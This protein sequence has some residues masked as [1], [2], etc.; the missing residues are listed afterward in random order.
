MSRHRGR[1]R[2]VAGVANLV[3]GLEF[4]STAAI[5]AAATLVV[6]DMEAGYDY[7]IALEA[8]APTTDGQIPWMRFSDDAGVSYEA[9]AGDYQWAASV[10]AAPLQ[11]TSDTAIVLSGTT[12][13]GND[14]ASYSTIEVKLINPN[15]SSEKTTAR[16]GGFIMDTQATQ[17]ITE[18]SGSGIFL[19]GTDA[20]AAVQFLWSG[21]ST[22]K[23]Q[24]DITVWRRR[25]S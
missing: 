1:D 9:D 16:W 13:V 17:E 11:S 21:G 6:T 18:I 7:F 10:V 19:Q 8:F 3:G 20:V 14:A 22:F 15:A 12:T 2:R 25:R 4:V 23:A 5:T 24:G